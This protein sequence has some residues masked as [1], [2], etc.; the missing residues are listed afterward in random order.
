M[1]SF[2]Y[3]FEP[4][5]AAAAAT[6]PKQATPAFPRASARPATSGTSGPTTT[7]STER[8]WAATASASTSSAATATS[9]A[10]AA[11]PAFPGAHRTSG[12]VG[13]RASARTSACSRPPEPTT[14][15]RMADPPPRLERSD[16]VVDRDRRQRLVLGGPARTQLQRDA[17]D[18]GLVGGLDDV[19]EVEVPERRPLRL[20]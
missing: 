11:M 14:S 6:G 15:T 20:D 16:E 13:D 8:S 9:S 18:R 12:A 19:H 1:T 3:D 10:S 17:R 7:R 2:A 4:S 5:S